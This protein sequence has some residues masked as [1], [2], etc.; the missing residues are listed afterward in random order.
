[1]LLKTLREKE[2]MVVTSI[3]SISHSIFYPSQN[4][5]QFFKRIYFVVC[6]CFELQSVKILA[7]GKELRLYK[8]NV[9][10]SITCKLTVDTRKILLRNHAMKW[11]F[12]YNLKFSTHYKVLDRLTSSLLQSQ[13]GLTLYQTVPSFD[14]HEKEA[15][16]KHSGKRRKCW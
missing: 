4:R 3:F 16:R 5:C 6:K 7:F 9:I 2:K 15:D 10:I 12:E 8:F 14:D 13:S 11:I 1:M